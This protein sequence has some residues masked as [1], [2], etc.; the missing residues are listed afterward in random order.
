MT[1]NY[2]L[3]LYLNKFDPSKLRPLVEPVLADMANTALSDAELDGKIRDALEKSR[4]PFI[5]LEYAEIKMHCALAKYSHK[6]YYESKILLEEALAK[7]ENDVHRKAITV[8][9]MGLNTLMMEDMSFAYHYFMSARLFM[10]DIIKGK[11][12][13]ITKPE[14]PKWYQERI[15]EISDE[16]ASIFIQEI[17][18]WYGVYEHSNLDAQA[19]AFSE[20]I[21]EAIGFRKTHEANRLIDSL[22]KLSELGRDHEHSADV[23]VLCGV[24]K[25]LLGA[26]PEAIKYFSDAISK[27]EPKSQRQA[28]VYWLKGTAQWKLPQSREESVSNLM[29]AVDL[30]KDLRLKAE[31][32]HQMEL[33]NWYAEKLSFMDRDIIKKEKT[34]LSY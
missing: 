5:P 9:M 34:L 30:F 8:W 14:T 17:Y 1:I 7:Y 31:K 27:L 18:Q 32:K 13:S 16:M 20:K 25:Y 22:I 2:D 33:Y 28:V 6:K 26:T 3:F 29:Q 4:Y 10:D 12:Y 19:I 24:A 15:R 21:F 11:K 23:F